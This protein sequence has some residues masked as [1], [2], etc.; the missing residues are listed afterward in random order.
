VE[1]WKKESAQRRAPYSKIG[2]DPRLPTEQSQDITK[3]TILWIGAHPDDETLA[4][5]TLAKYARHGHRVY[6][7]AICTGD[8][9]TLD[10]SSEEIV[11]IRKRELND[12]AKVLGAE[13]LGTLGYPDHKAYMTDELVMKIMQLVREVK[14]DMVYTHYHGDYNPDHIATSQATVSAI[15]NAS[16]PAYK[17]DRASHR[18]YRTI[19][20]DTESGLDFDPDFWIDI[21]DT[22]ETKLKALAC[23]KS[24]M[25]FLTKFPG[26]PWTNVVENVRTCAEYRGFQSGVKYAEAFK[27][28]KKSGQN[29]AFGVPTIA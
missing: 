24:Q 19:Y 3:L 9:G 11:S 23:H 4:S 5:G 8:K 27:L 17:T 16:N 26:Q 18:V 15:F 28:V 6:L 13:S 10:L 12:A 29:Y 25:A 7:C 21:S 20:A 2:E 14:P 22:I 1:D